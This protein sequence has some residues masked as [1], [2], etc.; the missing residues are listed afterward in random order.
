MIL[1]SVLYF[2]ISKTSKTTL[3]VVVDVTNVTRLDKPTYGKNN[4]S[5]F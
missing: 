4:S 1:T 3:S 5:L 2:V